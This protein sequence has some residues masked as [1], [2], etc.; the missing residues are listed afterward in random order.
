MKAQHGSKRG[1]IKRRATG[2]KVG[3]ILGR[4]R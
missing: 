3:R 4:Q 2:G 1:R